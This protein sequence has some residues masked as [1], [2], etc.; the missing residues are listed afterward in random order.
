MSYVTEV[1][2][3]LNNLPSTFKEVT[4]DQLDKLFQYMGVNLSPITLQ[5]AKEGHLKTLNKVYNLEQEYDSFKA[6][7]N[8]R[9]RKGDYSSF[10]IF[11]QF[12]DGAYNKPE[13][14]SFN[15]KDLHKDSLGGFITALAN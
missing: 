11:H 13:Q 3:F 15:Q 5:K 8:N 10:R 6:F 14:F 12:L 2:D 9:E 7:V 1:L 4:T